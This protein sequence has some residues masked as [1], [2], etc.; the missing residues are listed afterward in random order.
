[1]YQNYPF[2]GYPPPMIGQGGQHISPEA[3]EKGLQWAA[4]MEHRKAREKE[5]T[6]RNKD[7]TAKEAK[8]EARAAIGR[9]FLFVEWYI[10]GILSYPLWAPMYRA[11]MA[12]HGVQ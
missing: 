6:E 5:R 7:R 2:Y 10:L 9:T 4:K 11:F 1:M 12:T 3:F 8:R